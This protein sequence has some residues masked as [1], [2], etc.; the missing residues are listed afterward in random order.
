MLISLALLLKAASTGLAGALGAYTRHA[1]ARLSRRHLGGRFPWGT[2][3]INLTGSLAIGFLAALLEHHQRLAQWHT[4]VALGFLG[5]YTTFGTLMLELAQLRGRAQH[6]LLTAYLV[7]SAFLGPLAA[8]L[9][10][11]IGGRV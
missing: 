4:P 7:G 6:G 11:L 9:G 10:L 1:V 5:G 8:F 2:L 3:F